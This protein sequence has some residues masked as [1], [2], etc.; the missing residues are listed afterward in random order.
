LQAYDATGLNIQRQGACML[1][2]LTQNTN[3]DQ[4]WIAEMSKFRTVSCTVGQRNNF[5]ELHN[6]RFIFHCDR[7]YRHQ[8][9]QPCISSFVHSI[10]YIQCEK[11]DKYKCTNEWENTSCRYQTHNFQE[12]IQHSA[13]HIIFLVTAGAGNV[14]SSWFC[15]I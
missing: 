8:C 11:N 3:F 4:K 10:V 9:N 6:T 7:V 12:A 1:Q 13:L 15:V 5:N 2:K 14:Y